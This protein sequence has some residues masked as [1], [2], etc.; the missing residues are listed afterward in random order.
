MNF[1]AIHLN[2]ESIEIDKPICIGTSILDLSKL[3]MYEYLYNN[4][5][6]KYVDEINLLYVDTAGFILKINSEDIY[7][8]MSQ[9][10]DIY[11]TSNCKSD[12]LFSTKN[13]NVIGKFKDELGGKII[14]E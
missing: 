10:V 11:D 9:D 7:K 14:N 8:A 3:L 1:C 13:K 12:K 4:L 5:K 6:K 2:K